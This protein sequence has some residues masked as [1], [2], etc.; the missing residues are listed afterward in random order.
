M[1]RPAN[2]K[3]VVQRLSLFALIPKKINAHHLSR[4]LSR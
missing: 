1:N 4:H 3:A 2:V